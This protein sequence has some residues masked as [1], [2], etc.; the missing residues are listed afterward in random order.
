MSDGNGGCG[1]CRFFAAEGEGRGECRRRP[2]TI[3]DSI[4]NARIEEYGITGSIFE[5]TRWPV[6]QVSDWCGEYVKK[7]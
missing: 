5:A 3:V 2:P 1:D 4:S 7:S 6:V